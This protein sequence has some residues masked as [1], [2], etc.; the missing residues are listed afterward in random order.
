MMRVIGSERF[1]DQLPRRGPLGTRCGRLDLTYYERSKRA[2]QLLGSAIGRLARKGSH[3]IVVFTPEHTLLRAREPRMIREYLT[4]RL[5]QESGLSSLTVLDY[6]DAVSDDGF[7]D[8][9]HLNSKGSKQFTL[10][11]ARDLSSLK[12]SEQPKMQIKSSNSP[13]VALHARSVGRTKL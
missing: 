4:R 11:L 5:A 6:R 2:P 10:I 7:V 1:P 3:I 13:R 9:V 12:W 8:L